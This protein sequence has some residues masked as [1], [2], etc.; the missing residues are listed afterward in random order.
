MFSTVFQVIGMIT[1][2]MVVTLLILTAMGAVVMCAGRDDKDE[3]SM[4]GFCWGW[5]DT[6]DEYL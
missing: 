6:D 1:V 2:G 5:D 3:I 4:F